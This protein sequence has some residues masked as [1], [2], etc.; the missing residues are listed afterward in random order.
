VR[1]LVL[2]SLASIAFL[3]ACGTVAH[4]VTGRHLGDRP[5]RVGSRGQDVR[6]LQRLLA[7]DGLRV[8]VDGRFGPGTLAAVRQLQRAAGLAVD[9]V[10]RAATIAA[11]RAAISGGAVATAL[12]TTPDPASTPA[13]APGAAPATLDAPAQATRVDGRAVAPSGAPAAVVAAVSAANHIDTLPYRYGGGHAQWEDTAYDCSGSVG[14][15]LHGAGLITSTMTSGQLA[16]W[17]Q[18]GPGRWIT[19]YASADHTWVVIAGLRFDT[20]RYDTGATVNET[21]PRW[22]S[23]PRPADGFVVRHPAGL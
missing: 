21:G 12:A 19:I 20:G 23:G 17:G 1:R 10:V 14:Y 18:P 11:L 6:S 3:P 2:F 16:Q 8:T 5:L 7:R 13:A 9:G 15:A 4:A 22:R